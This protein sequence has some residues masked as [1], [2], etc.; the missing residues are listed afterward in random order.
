V[1]AI[2]V[3]IFGGIMKCDVIAMGVI[4]AA[5][6]IGMKKPIIIRLKGT[7]VEAA[8]KLIEGSGFRMIVED[9]FDKA[10]EKA[11]KMTEIIKL[12]EAAGLSVSA[13]SK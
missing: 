3:N 12:A 13:V 5:Q 4:N 10:A 1:K 8:N 11:V 7:N 9:D 6:A 2:F